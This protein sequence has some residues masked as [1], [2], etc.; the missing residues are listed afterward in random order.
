LPCGDTCPFALA[1]GGGIDN[2]GVLTVINTSV[3]D[4]AS[5]GPVAS[6][7]VGAGIHSPQG[8]LH[9]VDSSVTGNRAAAQRP[10]GRFAEG[11]G[12]FAT[13]TAFYT[14]AQRPPGTLTISASRVSGNSADLSMAFASDIEAHAQTGGVFIG[15]DDD[16]T[17]PDSGCVAASITASTVADNRVST[18]NAT[19]DAVAFA[20]GI[21]N[22]GALSLIRSRI[23][24]NRVSARAVAGSSAFADS[25]GLGMGGVATI[26][27]SLIT[28][29][30]VKATADAGDAL[31]SFGGI[32]FGTPALTTR[33]NR[34]VIAGNRV[35]ALSN[36]GTALA[37]G[38]GV[39]HLDGP[40][41]FS[42]SRIT[43][44][45]GVAVGPQ[46]V[47]QGGGIANF[48]DS[49]PLTLKHSVIAHNRLTTTGPTPPQGGGLY[50]TVPVQ[51]IKTI[52]IRNRPDQCFGC[53]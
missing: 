2:W 13:S 49:A 19:G 4:N 20:G 3:R 43:A 35:T 24:A 51:L 12:I 1:G 6:D 50:T 34:S 23:T 30:T 18:K 25:A 41:V 42:H 27:R 22:D 28:D 11:G 40:V 47:A 37:L 29:N 8:K 9:V 32:S 46:D 17:H 36:G 48:A 45:S 52:I 7:A 39:G 14:N 26:D 33:V 5:G 44:N 10:N 38:A 16:C 53:S 31:A 21:N 15:G